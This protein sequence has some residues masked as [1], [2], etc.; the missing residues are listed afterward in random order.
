MDEPEARVV[1]EFTHQAETLNR[2]P[3]FTL[4]QT[5]DALIAM[6]P[7]AAGQRW[8][9]V[10]CGSGIVGRALAPHVGEVVG[11][12]LTPAMLAVAT[13]EAAGRE[14]LRYVQGDATALPFAAGAFDG[15][16]TRFSL[17]HMPEPER[18]LAEMVRVVRAGGWVAVAD[19]FTAGDPAVAA[20]H[21]QIEQLR[22]P[23]HVSC[24][25]P[26]ALRR[27]AAELGLE[28]VTER[29]EPM[30]IDY[31]EWVTRGS[32]GPANRVRIEAAL[33]ARPHD[34]CFAVEPGPAGRRLHLTFGR[35]LWRSPALRKE[36]RAP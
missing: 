30:I 6:L 8:L 27:L 22:D 28:P 12:D 36:G 10:A 3:V 35:F 18:C 20:W 34:A 32:A 31:E 17:H 14:N 4:P 9:E 15:A 1:N 7:A 21:Q 33:A 23:S 2:S 16:V 11:V 29:V 19:H 24:L 5:L 26:A 13:R 25:T